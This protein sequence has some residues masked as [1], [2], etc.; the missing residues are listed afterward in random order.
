[1]KGDNIV[2]AGIIII[3]ILFI[4]SVRLFIEGFAAGF[5][6]KDVPYVHDWL[7]AIV[8]LGFG[9]YNLIKKR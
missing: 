4:P 7:L 3:G 2:K 6:G 9:I 5:V 8:I 1:M